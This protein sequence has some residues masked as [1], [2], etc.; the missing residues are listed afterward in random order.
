MMLIKTP[1]KL[2]VSFTGLMEEKNLDNFKKIL[3]NKHIR[4][5]L[6]RCAQPD[7]DMLDLCI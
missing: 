3:W 1:S 2:L 6:Y 7:S 4:D 5:E